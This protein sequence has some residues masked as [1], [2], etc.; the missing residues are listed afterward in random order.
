M[1]LPAKN[2]LIKYTPVLLVVIPNS[3]ILNL[4][5]KA[6]NGDEI[7]LSTILKEG[8]EQNIDDNETSEVFDR[9][10]QKV[11]MG[12][13][14]GKTYQFLIENY[15]HDFDAHPLKFVKAVELFTDQKI[16]TI[17]KYIEI[18]GKDFVK[19]SSW[20]K[21]LFWLSR[22]YLASKCIRYALNHGMRYPELVSKMRYTFFGY[23]ENKIRYYDEFVSMTDIY[24]SVFQ[25]GDLFGG[26]F[27]EY[28]RSYD[29]YLVMITL[30]PRDICESIRDEFERSFTISKNL[31][32]SFKN[33]SIEEIQEEK[34]NDE[35]TFVH[36]LAQIEEER[37]KMLE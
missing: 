34:K 32:E 11:L 5:K 16:N 21:D 19:K 22:T 24:K 35:L 18:I 9:D 36:E 17:E 6:L 23:N 13:K 3:E 1:I 8:I 30:V 15:V 31:A 33:K 37:N 25:F 27:E 10:V 28:D 26:N 4:C 12:L 29:D 14:N 2:E 20:A 7:S